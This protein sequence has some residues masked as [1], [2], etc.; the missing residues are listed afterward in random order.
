[1]Q[2]VQATLSVTGRRIQ[3][4]S[5][6]P[7]GGCTYD[8]GLAEAT[9][10]R[11]EE[12]PDRLAALKPR[13]KRWHLIARV[14]GQYCDQFVNV[15]VLKRGHIPVEQLTLPLLRRPHQRIGVSRYMLA[16]P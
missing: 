4:N 14:V 1:M 5:R 13:E 7:I 11:T 16:G 10:A 6:L 12:G 2:G 9:H 8:C 15:G 3:R